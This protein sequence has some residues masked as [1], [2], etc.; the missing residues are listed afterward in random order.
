MNEIRGKVEEILDKN[1]D[2]GQQDKHKDIATQILEAVCGEV[3]K[4][5]KQ[6]YGSWHLHYPSPIHCNICEGNKEY[7]QALV[8]IQSLLRGTK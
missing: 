2:C 7:N 6:V 1:C 8:D 3:G 4:M 5:E